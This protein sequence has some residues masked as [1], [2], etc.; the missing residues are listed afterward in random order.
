MIID[1]SFNLDAAVVDEGK[2]RF[3]NLKNS[4]GKLG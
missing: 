2:R 1:Q 4:T 3:K